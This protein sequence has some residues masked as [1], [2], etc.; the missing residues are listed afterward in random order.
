MRPQVENDPI[1][2]VTA[3]VKSLIAAMFIALAGPRWRQDISCFTGSL[4][5]EINNI[6]SFTTFMKAT[7]D[8]HANEET[9]MNEQESKKNSIC[10]EGSFH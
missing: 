2:K 4:S 3:A 6:N 7:A 5:L 8:Q 9:E 1:R 10:R